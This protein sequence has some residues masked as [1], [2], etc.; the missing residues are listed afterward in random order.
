[1]QQRPVV[2]LFRGRARAPYSPPR[3]RPLDLHAITR[4]EGRVRAWPG[5]Q[6]ASVRVAE[7][8][9]ADPRHVPHTLVLTILV[10]G[11]SGVLV[12]EEASERALLARSLV[13]SLPGGATSTSP[14]DRSS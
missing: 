12:V 6:S 14:G 8:V 3:R 11:V 13:A 7:W 9:S 1:M 2:H 5:Y 10:Q 4:I